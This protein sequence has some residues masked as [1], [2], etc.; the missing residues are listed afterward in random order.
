MLSEKFPALSRPRKLL[1][2]ANLRR[3]SP[4][5]DHLQTAMETSP[6]KRRKLEHQTS[7]GVPASNGAAVLGAA[8]AGTSRLSTFVLQAQELLSESR[9]DY[10][11]AFPGADALCHRL[12]S[13]IEAI[14][15]Q[16]PTPVSSGNHDSIDGRPRPNLLSYCRFTKLPPPS[17]RNTVLLCPTP[18]RNRQKI[19]FTKSRMRSPRSSTLSAVMSPRRW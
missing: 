2:A 14:G 6:A 17:R 13:T 15:P 7:S 12:K 5:P 16:S 1:D 9:I 4:G 11:K 3:T 10:E 19:H 18:N 8:A